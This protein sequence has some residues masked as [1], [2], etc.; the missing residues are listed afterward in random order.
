MRTR[1]TTPTQLATAALLTSAV[2][3]DIRTALR[4]VQHGPG[5]IRTKAVRDDLRNAMAT[6]GIAAA[7][8]R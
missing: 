8:G 2:G 1:D 4:A 6:L 5:C 7:G 3:C